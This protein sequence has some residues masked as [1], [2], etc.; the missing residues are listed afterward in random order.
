M[1]TIATTDIFDDWFTGLDEVVR[2]AVATKVELLKLT[3]PGLRR[4]HADT[5]GGSKHA[6]MRELRIDERGHVIRVAFAFDPG[7]LGGAAGGG[8]E[9]GDQPE[10]VVPQPHPPCGRV[11]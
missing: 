9:A 8:G 3:G 2:V 11:V 5:L 10:A 4:P 7:P 6:N 1:W